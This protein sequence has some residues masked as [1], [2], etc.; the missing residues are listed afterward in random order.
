[1]TRVF[2][3]S[4]FCP[5]RGIESKVWPRAASFENTKNSSGCRVSVVVLS[6]SG[7]DGIESLLCEAVYW[8]HLGLQG[9]GCLVILSQV[10]EMTSCP[11]RQPRG[12]KLN[13][14]CRGSKSPLCTFTH[15]PVYLTALPCVLE[16]A[17]SA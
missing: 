5:C 13:S 14:Q 7:L 16:K 17:A 15:A 10:V 12:D 9:T 6:A 2:A 1:M 8:G 3:A 4:T 11:F